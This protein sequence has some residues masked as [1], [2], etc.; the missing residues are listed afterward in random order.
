MSRT[1]V[2]AGGRLRDRVSPRAPAAVFAALGLVLVVAAV[3]V[4][5]AETLLLSWG[6]TALFLAVLLRFVFTGPTVPAAVTTAVYTTMADDA[7]RRAPDAPHR[8]VPGDDGVSLAVGGE[9][10]DPVGTRLLAA[11]ET[12]VGDGPAAERLAVVVDVVINELELAGRASAT[13]A[14]GEATVT[15]VGSRVGTAALFDHPVASVV[16][17]ALADALETGVRVDTS[18][19][20]GVLVVSCRWS[21]RAEE[22]LDGAEADEDGEDGRSDQ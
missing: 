13:T 7:R 9:T 3:A 4:P 15:V 19:E 12:P 22:L 6:G 20:D 16:G 8:Y 2:A 11:T 1:E 17:V 14:A 10:F 5:A 21:Q 18:V